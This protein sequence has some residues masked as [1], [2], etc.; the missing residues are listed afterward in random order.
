MAKQVILRDRIA[1]NILVTR[2]SKILTQNST[3]HTARNVII[4][5]NKVWYSMA[6]Q[7][8]LQ[9]R[10]ANNILVSG[11]LLMLMHVASTF[12]PWRRDARQNI[13]IQAS[14]YL[15]GRFLEM[16]PPDM[17]NTTAVVTSTLAWEDFLKCC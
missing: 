2:W 15:G 6:K 4:H 14:F 9:D 10:I 7:I 12:K 17:L 11:L 13:Y 5:H 8:I 1:K 3:V 16:P